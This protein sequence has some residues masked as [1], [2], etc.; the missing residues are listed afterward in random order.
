MMTSEGSGGLST[1]ARK[2]AQRRAD[3]NR[4]LRPRA[5]RTRARRNV[6]ALDGGPGPHRAAPCRPARRVDK[7][8]RRR[9]HRQPAPDDAGHE[10]RL[11][12]RRG[13]A[14]RRHRPLLLPVLGTAD[15]ARADGGPRRDAHPAAAGGGPGRAARADSLRRVGPISHRGCRLRPGSRC[16]GGDLQHGALAEHPARVGGLR[17]CRRVR[18]PASI[19]AGLRSRGRHGLC[20][21]IHGQRHGPGLVDS[22]GASRTA[23]APG[24]L[25]RGRVL[26]AARDTTRRIRP[27]LAADRARRAAAAAA[28]PGDPDRRLQL[29]A[30][31]VVGYSMPSTTFWALGCL[32]P[33]SGLAS[34]AGGPTWST[35]RVSSSCCSST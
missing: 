14:E 18:L 17:A 25:R 34:G 5:R 9:P 20:R 16:G 7:P 23:P 15:H 32:S 2:D 33:P 27:C 22:A 29:S 12:H 13:D 35:G 1:D 21:G 6:H 26:L 4:R 8:V 31:P 10:G 19:P 28:L 11:A 24:R 30:P 3:Q